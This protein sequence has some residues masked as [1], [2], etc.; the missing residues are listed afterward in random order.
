MLGLFAFS[1]A[2]G[3]N[4][5]HRYLFAEFG[6]PQTLC[7]TGEILMACIAHGRRRPGMVRVPTMHLEF[8]LRAFDN[9]AH[10]QNSIERDNAYDNRVAGFN[11][12]SQK[13]QKSAASVHRFV[14]LR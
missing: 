8:A 6:P 2:D 1:F 14:I 12:P 7:R 3:L 10:S 11:S 5:A 13:P 9:I 4:L